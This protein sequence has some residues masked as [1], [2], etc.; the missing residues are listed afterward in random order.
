MWCKFIFEPEG[1]HSGH[2]SSIVGLGKSAKARPLV[3]SLA[4]WALMLEASLPSAYS[5]N[6]MLPTILMVTREVFGHSTNDGW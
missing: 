6:A 3:N 4:S 1:P 2:E 5:M